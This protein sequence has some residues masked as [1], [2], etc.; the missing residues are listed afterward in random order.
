MGIL[1]TATTKE[2]WAAVNKVRNAR[3]DDGLAILHNPDT[4]NNYFANIA[5]KENYDPRNL[6]ALCVNVTITTLNH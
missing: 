1:N 6:K 3:Q 5:F 4:V 2:L